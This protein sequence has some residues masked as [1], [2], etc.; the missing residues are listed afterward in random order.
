MVADHH[1]HLARA[2]PA[3]TLEDSPMINMRLFGVAGIAAAFA[4]ASA[5]TEPSVA[6]AQA[7]PASSAQVG[8]AQPG[9]GQMGQMMAE[10]QKMQA[11]MEAQGKKLDALVAQMNT[12]KGADKV[13][14]VA[15]LLT[16]LVAQHNAM[17][18]RMM[19]PGGM[20]AA[21]MPAAP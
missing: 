18:R 5:L 8:Q 19:G 10:R 20:M 15:A 4:I 1:G 6:R 2:V 7:G 16:E 14:K 9:R 13:D 11:E 21:P 17:H 3:Y 12:A